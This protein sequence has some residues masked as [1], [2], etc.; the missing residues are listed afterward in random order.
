MPLTNS[1]LTN[2]VHVDSKMTNKIVTSLLTLVGIFLLLCHLELYM[3][4]S[5]LVGPLYFMRLKV[6]KIQQLQLTKSTSF[7]IHSGF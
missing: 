5:K 3:G 2:T 1:M 4:S 7:Y 6:S